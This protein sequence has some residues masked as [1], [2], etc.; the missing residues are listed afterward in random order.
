KKEPADPFITLPHANFTFHRQRILEL[1]TKCRLPSAHGERAGGESGGLMSYGPDIQ[2]IRRRAA[3]CDV[4]ALT[5]ARQAALPLEQPTNFE[6]IINLKGAKE[7]GLRIPANVLA[8][9]DR[10]LAESAGI[11]R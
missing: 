5:G 9:A 3:T 6:F 4:T 1:A 11:S 8:R 2:D 7:I 10:V